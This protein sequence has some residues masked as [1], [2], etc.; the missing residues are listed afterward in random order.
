MKKHEITLGGVYVA[1]VSGRLTRVRIDRESPHGGWD[2]TNI[3]TGRAIR[4][5]SAA[6]LRRGAERTRTASNGAAAAPA[7]ET[8][9]VAIILTPDVQAH[10]DPTRVIGRR[11]TYHGDEHPYLRGHDVVIVAVLKDAL[12]VEEHGYLKTEED[13]CATGGVSADDRIEIAP[14][15]PKEGRLSFV[16]S[17]P[18]A[19]DLEAFRHLARGGANR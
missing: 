15:L 13:V 12:R 8:K 4:V 7:A 9:G 16:T 10:D 17:D 6:R 5:R 18:R 14:F 1:K 11:T 2:A 3:E 19:I